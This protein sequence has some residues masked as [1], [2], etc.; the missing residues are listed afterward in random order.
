MKPEPLK[1]DSLR[2][3]LRVEY[4]PTSGLPRRGLLTGRRISHGSTFLVEVFPEGSS[5][6]RT[7]TWEISRVYLLPQVE[8]PVAVGGSFNPPKGYP[9]ISAGAGGN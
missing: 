9:F 3:N 2:K 8:Q 4:R 7:D 6:V 1:I 5:T